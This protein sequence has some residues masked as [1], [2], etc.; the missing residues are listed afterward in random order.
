MM[1]IPCSGTISASRMI[2]GPARD[3]LT[4][5]QVNEV[6][7]MLY[8]D[9]PDHT[10]LRS[11]VS[12]AFTRGAIEAMYPRIEEIVDGLLN[13]VDGH[14]RFDAMEAL[15]YP[16]PTIV[17]SEMLGVPPEDRAQFRGWSDNLAGGLEPGQTTK[18]LQTINESLDA[19][20][21]YFDGIIKKRRA[22]P[23]EDLVTALSVAEE[24]G[25]KLKP[26]RAI[27]DTNPIAGGR[28]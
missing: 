13:Q 17:I 28:K 9:P 26:P 16:L 21:D 23:R 8:L 5:E 3:Q 10:R 4:E 25:E 2:I 14:Q 18:E 24:E 1:L 12:Q 22:E 20:T 27:E 6:K 15:A 11:L 7:S 19:L